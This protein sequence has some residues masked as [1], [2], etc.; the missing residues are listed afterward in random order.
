MEVM[1]FPVA[2]IIYSQMEVLGER[3]STTECAANVE[4]TTKIEITC[5]CPLFG[6]ASVAS[7]T[8]KDNIGYVIT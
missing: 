6:I 3:V 4:H 8:A 2:F 1:C 7:K 5:R